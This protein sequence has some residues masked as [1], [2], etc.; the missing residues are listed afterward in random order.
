MRLK[1]STFSS[2]GLRAQHLT[3]NQKV[4]MTRR[5]F[6]RIRMTLL[7]KSTHADRWWKYDTLVAP[8]SDN[9]GQRLESRKEI[10]GQS[11]QPDWIENLI[12]RASHHGQSFEFNRN[13]KESEIILILTRG[14]DILNR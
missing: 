5:L 12:T 9:F 7:P 10:N 4:P 3:P 6:C 11:K 2:V 13:L 14:K 8:A 1:G